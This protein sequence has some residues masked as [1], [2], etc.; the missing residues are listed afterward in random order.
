MLPAKMS[1][2]V[3]QYRRLSKA[4]EGGFCGAPHA[5]NENAPSEYSGDVFDV[6]CL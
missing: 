4:E 3:L 1:Y 2:R 5:M 6:A